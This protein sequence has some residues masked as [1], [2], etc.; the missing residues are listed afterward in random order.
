M[1]VSTGRWF[2]NDRLPR[3]IGSPQ[4]A[5][6]SYP[7]CSRTYLAAINNMQQSCRDSFRITSF[8]AAGVPAYGVRCVASIDSRLLHR[9]NEQSISGSP[10]CVCAGACHGGELPSLDSR[11][12]SA[13]L[14]PESPARSI[15]H[16]SLGIFHFTFLIVV[17]H[18]CPRSTRRGVALALDSFSHPLLSPTSVS[19]R[20]RTNCCPLRRDPHSLR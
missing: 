10:A 14:S 9:A 6:P 1:K 15:H 7:P 17:I 12:E 8:T 19:R 18:S 5:A 2:G 3:L 20:P 4:S 11:L 13:N 16:D